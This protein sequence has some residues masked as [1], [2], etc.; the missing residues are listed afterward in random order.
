MSARKIRYSRWDGSQ[1][2]FAA[3]A[4]SGGK[5]AGGEGDASFPL[6]DAFEELAENLIYGF[7]AEEAFEWMMRNGFQLPSRNFRVMGLSDL[8][9]ELRRRREEMFQQANLDSA[10]DEIRQKLNDL[11][12]FELQTMMQ[13]PGLDPQDREERENRLDHLPSGLAKAVE[14]LENYD[15]LDERAKELYEELRERLDDIRDLENFRD[16][17][18]R[19]FTGDEQLDFNG[20]VEMMRRFQRLSELEQALESGDL[21]EIS[22]EELKDMLSEEG[23]QSFLILRDLRRQFE[24]EGLIGGEGRPELTPKAIRKIGARALGDIYDGLN[25]ESLGP[26]ETSHRGPGRVMPESTK[27]YQYG[28]AFHMDLGRTFRNALA[29]NGARLP[30]RIHPDDMEVHDIEHTTETATA[31]LIDMSWSMSWEGRFPAAKKVALALSHLIRTRFPRDKFYAVGFYTRARELQPSELPEMI[32][33]SGDP[34]TNLQEGLAVADRLLM[35]HRH[36]NRQII[37]VTDGQPTAYVSKGELMVE[38]PWDFGGI[39]PRASAETL[40]EVERVSAH[41]IR[42]NT[43]MLDDSPALVGFIS[44]LSRINKGRAFYTRPNALGRY[45]LVDYLKGRRERR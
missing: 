44:K 9:Q 27:P 20:G 15:F 25:R 43:F 13:T 14:S 30:V 28:D 1:K 22:P 41:G 11:R 21:R 45:L 8:M 23:I 2:P 16:R 39:S 37:L 19:M 40:K 35:R 17:Y 5:E 36:A 4:G 10:L 6:N 32:W 38:W 24:K 18:D 29:R 31:M 33:N 42:I 7:N 26:H 12:T 3:D 34:F